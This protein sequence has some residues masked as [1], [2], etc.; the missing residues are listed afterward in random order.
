MRPCASVAGT[1]CT[2]WT[3]DLELQP[4]EHAVAGDRGDRLL[5]AA[6]PPSVTLHRP[7]PSSPA[8]RRSAGTC[9]TGR[10]ANSAASSPPV[11]ARTSRIAWRLVASSFGQQQSF[12]CCSSSGSRAFSAQPPPRPAPSSPGRRRVGQHR[13]E[14]VE[15]ACAACAGSRSPATIGA[16]LGVFL[17]ELGELLARRDR[18][19]PPISA[20]QLFMARHDAVELVDREFM[21]A[22]PCARRRISLQREQCREHSVPPGGR[23]AGSP[24]RAI[25]AAPRTDRA[26]GG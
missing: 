8:A 13:L 15:L 10:P 22:S 16:E 5:V 19:A 25:R 4:R 6:V 11:P 26:A 9:G 14:A 20:A 24:R 7:R 21:L 2:R 17:R 18:A 1:R 23:S 3:P 12:T